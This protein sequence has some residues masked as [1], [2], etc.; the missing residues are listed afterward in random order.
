[1]DL[2]GPGPQLTL[3]FGSAQKWV[4]GPLFD[5]SGFTNSPELSTLNGF[6]TWY[7]I[8][9]DEVYYM[10]GTGNPKRLSRWTANQF[11]KVERLLWNESISMWNLVLNLPKNQCDEY[12][13]CGPYGLCD[14]NGSPICSCLQG[15]RPKSQLEWDQRD[16][17]S[18]CVR[19]TALDCKNSTDGFLNVTYTSLPDTGLATIHNTISFDECRLMCLMNCSCTGYARAD[20]YGRGCIIWVSELIGVGTV[21]YGGRDV[22]VRLASADLDICICKD[23]LH[24]IWRAD[25]TKGTHNR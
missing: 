18:G 20:V 17:S 4:S 9:R 8:S 6:T 25:A 11:G 23:S 1:M 7:K 16:Y 22:Y 2:Q 15:F 21:S 13:P 19:L 14:L 10:F 12:S 5:V 3:W 24:G